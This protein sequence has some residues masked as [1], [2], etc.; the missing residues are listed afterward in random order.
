MSLCH[1]GLL[2]QQPVGGNGKDLWHTV[3]IQAWS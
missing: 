1:I 2:G 3:G